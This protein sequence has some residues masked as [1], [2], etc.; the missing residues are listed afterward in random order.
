MRCSLDRRT[1]E[2][3]F[4]SCAVMKK[5]KNQRLS[6]L[7]HMINYKSNILRKV[8]ATDPDGLTTNDKELFAL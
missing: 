3:W 6:E 2:A 4:E 1:I 7:G 8:L 5:L